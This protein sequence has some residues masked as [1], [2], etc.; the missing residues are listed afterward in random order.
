MFFNVNKS[1]RNGKN[2]SDLDSQSMTS[3]LLVV[4]LCLVI[5]FIFIDDKKTNN[6][7][8]DIDFDASAGISNSQRIGID[9]GLEINDNK[10]HGNLGLQLGDNDDRVFGDA[11]INY[12][13]KY[14]LRAGLGY[15]DTTYGLDL[16]YNSNDRNLYLNVGELEG[17]SNNDNNKVQVG[18]GNYAIVFFQA[19]WCGYCQIQANLE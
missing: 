9:T 15:D 5:Y 2:K 17:F 13:K 19:D 18:Q 1:K 3:I 14:G 16:G 12:N 7:I 4:I 11:R 10:I 8:V 6:K